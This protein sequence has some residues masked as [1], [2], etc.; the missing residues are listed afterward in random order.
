MRTIAG[1]SERPQTLPDAKE[2]GARSML[3]VFVPGP[4]T[5]KGREIA[6][7]WLHFSSPGIHLIGY[8][9]GGTILRSAGAVGQVRGLAAVRCQLDGM[10]ALKKRVLPLEVDDEMF[11]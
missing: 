6:T 4:N 1:D 8:S 2:I 11:C 10:R 7:A 9:L 3:D 5:Y